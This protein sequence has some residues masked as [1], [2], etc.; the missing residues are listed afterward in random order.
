MLI[1]HLTTAGAVTD[2]EVELQVAELKAHARTANV[3]DRNGI[4]RY[5]ADRNARV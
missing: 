2:V 5:P 1:W 3:R 4:D